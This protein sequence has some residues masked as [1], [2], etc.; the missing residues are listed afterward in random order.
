DAQ[1]DTTSDAEDLGLAVRVV[2]EGAWGFAS[3]VDRTP[4]AAAALAEQ[5]VATARVSQMLSDR[6]V[7]FADEPTYAD[8]TWV[9][10]YDV[11]PFDVP[12]AERIGR[13]VELSERLLGADGVDHVAAHLMQVQENKYYADLAGTT[14]L[15]QRVRVQAQFT[16]VNV[17]RGAGTFSSM[18]T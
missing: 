10:S 8:A 7:V 18:R 3:G 15:Q 1:L 6:P 4:E 2:H 11:N 16:A 17:D 9:S 12:E 5:A 13:L 14:T